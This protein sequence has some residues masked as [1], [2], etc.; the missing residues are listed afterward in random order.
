[1]AAQDRDNAMSG[2]LRQSLQADKATQ[3]ECL[4]PDILAAYYERSLASDEMSRCEDHV[5]RCFGCRE[6]LAA[7]ARTDPLPQEQPHRH[8]WL[9]DWRLLLSAT[10]ALLILTVW[11]VR[12][13]AMTPAVANQPLVAMS[14]AGQTYPPQDSLR[15][16]QSPLSTPAA[17]PKIA[18]ESL[19]LRELNEVS[20][21]LQSPAPERPRAMQKKLSPEISLNAPGAENSLKLRSDQQVAQESDRPTETRAAG[22]LDAEKNAAPSAPI[23]QRPTVVAQLAAPP[24]ASNARVSAGAGNVAPGAD[25]GAAAE[26]PSAKQQSQSGAV[27]DRLGAANGL[28][29]Q[30]AE[31]RSAQTIIPTPNPKVLWRIAGGG[32]IERS[33]DGGATWLGQLPESNAH[34]T[35]GAAP[36]TKVLWLVGENGMILL[37]KDA[38]HWKKISPPIPADFVSVEASSATSATLTAADRQ[39]FSTSD[40]GKKWVPVR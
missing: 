1:M 31:Q 28:P 16:R 14:R 4:S 13:S 36:A 37:T 35:A 21:Q 34:F 17:P 33:Q 32:F 11:G 39:R 3:G 30:S 20:P 19:P 38:S 15:L 27:F 23:P 5:S 29:A 9:L 8:M 40:S 22:T 18:R 25:A 2:L 12:R 24:S 7:L 6:Q 26:L 10:A